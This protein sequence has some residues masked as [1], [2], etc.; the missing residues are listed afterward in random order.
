MD[1]LQGLE[2]GPVPA[3]DDSGTYDYASSLE[4]MRLI[5]AGKNAVAVDMIEALVMKC[6]PSKV[7][8]LSKL[9]SDGLGPRDRRRSPSSASRWSTWQRL[10]PASRGASVREPIR[11]DRCG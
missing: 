10:S 6:D 5:L 9:Q 1:G 3:W 7:P 2:H 11:L 4:N 8:H